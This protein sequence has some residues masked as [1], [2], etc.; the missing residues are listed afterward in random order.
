MEDSIKVS[1]T[2]VFNILDDLG[3]QYYRRY[4]VEG[5]TDE[6][7]YNAAL[8]MLQIIRNKLED[9]AEET[10]ETNDG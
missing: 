3:E 9:L 6:Q 7:A 8:T 10:Y 5:L 4:D 1:V 2:D